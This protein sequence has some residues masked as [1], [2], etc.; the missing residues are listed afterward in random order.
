MNK[1]KKG[2]YNDLDFHIVRGIIRLSGSDSNCKVQPEKITNNRRYLDAVEYS[3]E[4]FGEKVASSMV[5]EKD[6]SHCGMSK[7]CYFDFAGMCEQPMFICLA[8][9]HTSTDI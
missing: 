8:C 5:T 7:S 6:C 1:V 2:Y 3:L 4:T 9:G